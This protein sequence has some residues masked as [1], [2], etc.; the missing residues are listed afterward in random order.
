MVSYHIASREKYIGKR[1][2]ETN[3]GKN[4]LLVSCLCLTTLFS[5]LLQKDE[6]REIILCTR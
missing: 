4:N 2:V 5:I 3:A 6:R 1:R